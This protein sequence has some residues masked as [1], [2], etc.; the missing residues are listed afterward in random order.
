MAYIQLENHKRK[1]SSI[2][3]DTPTKKLWI[4][5]EKNKIF[6]LI[7]FEQYPDYYL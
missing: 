4:N 5:K 3:P 1:T 2:P 7:Q 6:S